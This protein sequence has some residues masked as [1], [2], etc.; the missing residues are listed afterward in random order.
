MTFDIVTIFPA[1]IE[2]ALA[3]GVVGRAIERGSL[4]VTVH[5]LRQFTSDRHHVVDDVPYGG[6][7]GMV[8]KPEPWFRALDAITERG[9]ERPHVVLT[10]PQGRRF[11]QAVAKELSVRRHLVMLCGRYEGIDERV[12]TRVD[13]ELSIGDYVLSGGEL[14]A[15][16]IVDAVARLLPGVV[17]DEQSVVE[18]SF[19]RGLLDFPHYT[20]PAELS[21]PASGRPDGSG[22]AGGGGGAATDATLK[23]PSVL[24]SGNHA[25]IRRWRKRQALARTLERRPDLLASAVLDEEE[26]EILRELVAH[27]GTTGTTEA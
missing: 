19:T 1:M 3:V 26:R 5:D 20:R 14:P 6:G 27:E 10:S 23:V 25:A 18:E 4:A 16:V 24:L 8:M 11:T 22:A 9:P 2:G 15:L 7:P 17:G 13:D 21:G 12:R